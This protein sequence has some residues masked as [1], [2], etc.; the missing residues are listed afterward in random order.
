MIKGITKI[1]FPKPYSRGN[2][3]QQIL[4][5]SGTQQLVEETA[6]RI[7]AEANANNSRGGDGF[8]VDSTQVKSGRWIANVHSADK[9][10]AAAQSEDDALLKAVHG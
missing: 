5:S 3:F 2:G 1:V 8:A 6:R 9:E 7:C 4:E 10:S